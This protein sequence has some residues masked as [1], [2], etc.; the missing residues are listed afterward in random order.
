[1]APQHHTYH[2]SPHTTFAVFPHTRC[3]EC[4][5]LAHKNQNLTTCRMPQCSVVAVSDAHERTVSTDL[6][7]GLLKKVQRVRRDLRVVIITTL[8]TAA[9]FK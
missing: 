3:S 6:L 2:P 4:H 5:N 8:P 7:L 1:M 9:T